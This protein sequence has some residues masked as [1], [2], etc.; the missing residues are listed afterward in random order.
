[1]VGGIFLSRILGQVRETV[2][3]IKFGQGVEA[4]MYRAAFSIP[5]VLF[6]LVAGGALSSAFIPVFSESLHTGKEEEAWRLFGVI[7]T[8]MALVVAAFV[9]ITEV[10]APQLVLVLA[11]GF[12]PSEWQVQTTALLSRIVLPAQFGF[13]LGGLMFATFYARN[14][15]LL[16]VLA[17]NIY[18]LGIILGA[19]AIVPFVVPPV[20]GLM[21]GALGGALIGS[22]LLPG[23]FFFRTGGRYIPSLNVRNPEVVR[24]VKLMLPVILGLGLS[25]VYALILR[26]F[27]STETTGSVAAIDN[28]NRLMQAPLGIF[29]QALALAVFPTLCMFA[30]KKE[31]GL[32]TGTLQRSFRAVLFLTIPVAGFMLVLPEDLLRVLL[33]YGRYTERDTLYAAQALRLFAIGIPAWAAY[34]VMVRGFYALQ[35]TVTPVVLGTVVTLLFVPLCW[36]LKVWMGYAGLALASSIAALAL[37]AWLVVAMRRKA[38]SVEG[39]RLAGLT[40]GSVV[41]AA[42]ACGVGWLFAALLR[43]VLCTFTSQPNILS[44]AAVLGGAG[45]IG[46]TYLMLGKVLELEETK[47]ALSMIASRFG[48]TPPQPGPGT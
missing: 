41:A 3:A 40:A 31:M 44:G 43:R 9:L 28:A 18:N 20:S 21:W 5:D 24:V 34:A 48:R 32:F 12:A 4:D 30:A 19:L 47:Y 25:G 8:F 10:L 11:P 36:V 33:Q 42:G 37:I 45:V 23:W 13:F 6:F 1:M 46:L 38:G 2:I 29:G 39:R 26:A 35:D 17:P 14:H 22:L 16:P 7:G 27:A 15:F